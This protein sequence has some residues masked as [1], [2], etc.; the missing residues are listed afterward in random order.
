MRQGGAHCF[1][2][3]V[4]LVPGLTPGG[5]DWSRESQSRGLPPPSPRTH[6]LGTLLRTRSLLVRCMALITRR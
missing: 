2:G 3:S 1:L 5:E 6:V 4:Q